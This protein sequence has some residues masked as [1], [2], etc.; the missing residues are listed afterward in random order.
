MRQRRVRLGVGVGWS[1]LRWGE[2]RWD[3]LRWDG[4]GWGRVE[5]S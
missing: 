5:V 4:M 2:V 1:R 3:G